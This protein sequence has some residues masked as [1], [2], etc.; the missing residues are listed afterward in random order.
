MYEQIEISFLI[1]E[2]SNIFKKKYFTLQ[3]IVVLF[4]DREEKL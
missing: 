3:K 4:F 2:I 1:Y